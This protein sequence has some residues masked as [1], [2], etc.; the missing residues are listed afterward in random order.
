MFKKLIC[1][2]S[3]TLLLVLVLPGVA[4]DSDPSIVGWWKFEESSGTLYDQSDNHNDSTSVEGVLYQQTG[5]KGYALGFDGIDDS[6]TVGANGRPTDTFSYGGW[7][8]TSSTHEIDPESIS[9]V[10]GVNN[11]RY[12]FDPQ[13]GGETN[14]GAGLS[15]GTNGILVYE[16]GSNYMPATAVYQADIGTDWNHIMIVYDNKQP[17][18]YLNGNAVRTGLPSPRE[19]VNAPIHFGGMVYGYFEGL[20]DEV[21]IYNRALSAAEIKKLA[22]RPNAYSPIPDN[23]SLHEDTWVSLGW[24]PGGNAASHDVYLGDNFDEV[25]EGAEKVFQGSQADTFFVVGFPGFPYPDGLVPGTT[26]YWRVDEVNDTEP[27]S[28]WRGKVWSFSIPPKTAYLPEPADGAESVHPDAKLS[29]TAGFGSKLHYLYFGD[30]FDDVNN[31]TGGLPQGT[32]G[33]TPGP[34]RMS[35]TYYWRVDEFDIVNT[36]KG[37]VWSFTTEGAVKALSPI[38]GAMDV[39]QTPILSWLPSDYA[40][41]HQVYFGTD[42]VVVHNADT[43]SPE[44]KG[45]RDLGSESYDA[46]Q[47][48]WNTTYYWRIDE[49][50]NTNADSPWVGPVWSFTTANFL[51]IDD[52]EAYNDLNEDEP[53]SNR[54]YLAW[55]DGF[56][57]PAINGSIVGHANAPFAEQTIVHSG[58]Q[59]MPFAYDNAVGKSEATLTL[60]SNRDWTVKGVD[61]LTVWYQG[62]SANAA[63]PMYVVLNGTAAVTNDNPNAAQTAAWTE[64]NIDL[65]RFADQGVNLANVTSI[66]LGLGNRSNPVAG[67]AGMLYFDDIRLYAPAP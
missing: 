63:E 55:V 54:I 41:S 12:A 23:G 44:Y 10:G 2:F 11:Q 14:G 37:D 13:H 8:K 1:L 25:N 56:D 7:F 49:V 3:F 48:E 19:V 53:G 35:K 29:W 32:V 9:G 47:L 27:N 4:Q 33:Y 59:S 46:G 39:T 5:Q 51:I 40:A 65:T 66:T 52:F 31:A 45:S 6:I 57:N 58:N 17:T 61:R 30:N 43:S 28:P 62:G 60:T 18:I 50:D 20:M 64:W 26:Y 21:R 38:N 67:G 34:L 42:K 16:H 15:L 36:Y 22:A 24:S